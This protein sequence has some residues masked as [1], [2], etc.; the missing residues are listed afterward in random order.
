VTALRYIDIVLLWLT[1]PL[2]LLAGAPT[3]GVLVAAVAWTAQR[4]VAVGVDRT[5]RRREH[6]REAIGLNM[7]AML[8]RMW[9][10]G[11]TVLVAGLAGSRDD[12]VAAAVLLLAAYTVAFGTNLLTRSYTSRK[13]T[14]A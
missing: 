1:V 14:H 8:A 12:G 6:V 13:P 7:A 10:L 3:L 9:F 4:L 11:A 2:L 5:A